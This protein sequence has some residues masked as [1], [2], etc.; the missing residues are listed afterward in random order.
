MA[1]LG[2]EKIASVTL[3][4]RF[5][6]T[7]KRMR[8]F[9]ASQCIYPPGSRVVATE[10]SSFYPR[11]V[12]VLEQARPSGLPYRDICLFATDDLEFAYFF[13]LRQRWPSNSIRLYEVKMET[14]HRGPMAIV[15]AIDSHIK[16]SKN[17]SEL[18]AEYWAPQHKWHYFE[19]V[20]PEMEIV[21]SV[22]VPS[23]NEIIMS[24]NYQGDANKA[25]RM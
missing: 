18:L 9:H 2:I 6:S 22:E 1:C 4:Y 21:G 3:H 16:E 10:Q 24:L 15:H 5:S 7:L 11:A 23:I 25:S 13:A 17:T 8:L 19:C 20:G 14:F 12:P